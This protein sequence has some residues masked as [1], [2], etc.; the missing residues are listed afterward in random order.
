MVATNV[1][2]IGRL[3]G[4]FISLASLHFS[5]G[6]LMGGW[7]AVM[8][9]MA[10][11]LLPMHAELNPFGWLTMLIYGMTY[12]VLA[13]FAKLRPAFPWLGWAHLFSAETGILLICIGN[14][15]SLLPWVRAGYVA[16][17]LAPLLFMAAILS[18]V[19]QKKRATVEHVDQPVNELPP[20]MAKILDASSWAQKTDPI[21]QRG[22]DLALIV[23]LVAAGLASTSTFG[24]T[25][26][27][28]VL[29]VR[30][31]LLIDYGWIA[32][33][34]FSVAL[35]LFPRFAQ[36]AVS[37]L[38]A[39]IGQILWMVGNLS[40]FLGE[41]VPTAISLGI[42]F[43]GGALCLNSLFYLR[44]LVT[45]RLSSGTAIWLAWLGGWGFA[46]VLGLLLLLGFDPQ[47]LALLHLL[48]LGWMTT[49][50]Y[51]IGQTFF[52][53]LLHQAFPPTRF[54]NVQVIAALMGALLF[55]IGLAFHLPLLTTGGGGI[56]ALAAVAFLAFWPLASRLPIIPSQAKMSP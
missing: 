25:A 6:A 12:A 33:T 55:I 22:T 17:A 24:A 32:G 15:C 10:P 35:H 45:R 23:F 11:L 53:V 40:I 44:H 8:P 43:L 47:S 48:F 19:V 28:V 42:R 38:W 46:F 50:V 5:I 2:K 49:L 56:S 27:P 3:P 1:V 26:V 34:V 13:L 18:A 54:A 30:T 9:S 31:T 51:G 37:R 41:W 4:L 39:N 52:P 20:S 7:M 29:S 36:I 21:A 16:Q 14:L